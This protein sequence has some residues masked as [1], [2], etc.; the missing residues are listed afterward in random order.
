MNSKP[1]SWTGALLALLALTGCPSDDV[2]IDTDDGTSTGGDGTTTTGMSMTTMEP[3]TADGTGSS[4]DGN[5]ET[6]EA[7]SSTTDVIPPPEPQEFVVTIENVSNTGLMWSPLSP[8]LWA[9]HEAGADV[10]FQAD[11][12]DDGEGLEALAEDGDP[13]DLEVAVATHPGVLQSG[14]FDTPTMA[15]APGPLLPGDSYEFSFVAEPGTRLSFATMLVGSNDSVVATSPVGVSLFAGGGQPLG[16]R[17]VSSSLR[18]WDAGTEIDQAPGQGP[19][20]A[21]HG[22]SPNMGPPEAMAVFPFD[23]STRALPLGPDLVR[24]EVDDDP[25]SPGTF[26]ITLTN[27][28]GD[29][30]TLVTPLSPL[31]WAT[32][33]DAIA[34]FSE[35]AAASPE[36]EALA[37]DGEAGPLDALLGGSADV[38]EHAVLPGPGGGPI[39]PGESVSWSLTPNG[40]FPYLSLASMV[41]Q[42]NDAFLAAGPVRDEP[43]A[44]IP[45]FEDGMLRDNQD[46]EADIRA[47]LTPWDAGTE[48]N[49]VPGVGVDQAPRQ[50][51]PGDGAADPDPTVRRYVDVTNDLSGDSAGGFLTV[52]VNFAGGDYTIE[53]INT[54]DTTVYPGILTPVLW[55][56]HDD[57]FS[58]FELGMPASPGLELLAE[59]GDPAGLLGEVMGMAGVIASGVEDTRTGGG[60]PMPGPIPPG[61]SYEFTVTPD[62]TNRFI[63]FATMIMPSNDTFASVG[64]GGVALLDAMGNPIAEEAVAADIAIQLRAWDAGTE[65]NQAGAAGRDMAPMG[66][67]NTGPGNGSGTVR[68]A[69]AD[70]APADD[71]IWSMPNAEDVIRVVVAPAP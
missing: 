48:A 67:P 6:G 27:V 62:A 10:L 63:S 3:T 70:P 64:P 50:G 16:E 55:A 11:V 68:V 21:L 53:L 42:S 60:M 51:G 25:M 37:E 61:E 59:D 15:G 5:P 66:M 36:L 69:E 65:G 7:E 17:D 26:I 43:V 52:V 31:L 22:G 28:S 29:R 18:I 71:R 19:A 13:T 58:L 24:V 14:V 49:Q 38:G 2:P 30:G 12:P 8:G 56:L 20:Q 45:L 46:I 4:S 23:Y 54:S 57:T 35:G 33:T 40:G 1:T 32:H 39:L 9:N 47:H 34:L 44:G 41:G